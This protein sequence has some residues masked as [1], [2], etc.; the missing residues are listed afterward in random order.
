[1]ELIVKNEPGFSVVLNLDQINHRIWVY[2]YNIENPALLYDFFMKLSEDRGCEKVIFPVRQNHL[3]TLLQ[4]GFT[5]EGMIEGYYQGSDAHFLAA[6]PSAD[7]GHS[8]VLLNEQQMIKEIT[9][10]PRGI[11]KNLEEGFNIKIASEKDV[12]V[13]A[14]LFSEV[15]SSYPT[16][17]DD[18][19]YLA[20]AMESEDLYMVIYDDKERLAAVATAEIDWEYRRAELT[21]CA[22]HPDYR[23]MGLNRILLQELEQ[24][25]LAKNIF[26]LYSLA[27]ASSFGM[28]LVLHRLG[29]HFKGILINNCHIA[30]KYEDMN[31]WVKPTLEEDK[32]LVQ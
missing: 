7:R 11:H 29:Y 10:R 23:G 6:Y 22:T 24:Q 5:K 12:N 26:C 31:I 9:A 4:Q 19:C 25:C 2:D 16:A 14:H 30:G 28:N 13:M 8:A 21:N 15:F 32:N 3:S 20:H 1:M 18:P 27:R 17:V